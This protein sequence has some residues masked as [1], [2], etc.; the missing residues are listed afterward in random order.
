MEPKVDNLPLRPKRDVEMTDCS[1]TTELEE[2]GNSN[3]VSATESNPL[4]I[5][6]QSQTLESH[7][8]V[9][10]NMQTCLQSAGSLIS[11]MSTTLSIDTEQFPASDFNHSI[12]GDQRD[13]IE[14]WV[15]SAEC[16]S[17]NDDKME[18]QGSWTRE[19]FTCF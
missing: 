17:S 8:S 15:T 18:G 12:T 14:D 6:S 13:G 19:F 16:K 9:M 11:S 5:Q 2:V 3:S 7:I 4:E 10:K 1:S